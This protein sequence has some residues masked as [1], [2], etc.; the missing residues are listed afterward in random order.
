[1]RRSTE[2]IA[3]WN[4]AVLSAQHAVK[5]IAKESGHHIILENIE[6]LA[7]DAVNNLDP[8]G[9]CPFLGKE[10]WVNTE[11]KF[12]PCCAPDKER[13]RLGDFGNVHAQS[14]LQIWQSQPYQ[15]LR[16]DYQ[17]H[18]LCQGCNMRKALEVYT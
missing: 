18:G 1:M 8:D 14:I 3:R 7:E 17:Q 6:V 4:N 9:V 11:G 16:K 5:H 2:S 15:D 12:S 13:E 10:A